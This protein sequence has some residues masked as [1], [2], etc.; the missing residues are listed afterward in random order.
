MTFMFIQSRIYFAIIQLLRSI[1]DTL[2]HE[3]FRLS[4]RIDTQDVESDLR[5]RSVIIFSSDIS[6]T[7]DED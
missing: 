5:C 6:I 1:S 7:D 3:W 4:F 2:E